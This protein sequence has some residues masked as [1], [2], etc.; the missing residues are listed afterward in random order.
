MNRSSFGTPRPHIVP[1]RT[2][3]APYV[4]LAGALANAN[5]LQPAAGQS[6][7]VRH[8]PACWPAAPFF[9]HPNRIIRD[10]HHRK[11]LDEPS[12]T[13][14]NH[15]LHHD[16]SRAESALT[17]TGTPSK[18][19]GVQNR[20]AC[21][22]HHRS[23]PAERARP[24]AGDQAKPRAYGALRPGRRCSQ[25]DGDASHA[26]SRFLVQQQLESRIGAD[27]DYLTD[28]RRRHGRC[29]RWRWTLLW[30]VMMDIRDIWRQQSEE[31]RQMKRRREKY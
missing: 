29:F 31:R 20:Y 21:F 6:R 28:P 19:H 22:L 17:V 15:H 8:N 5:L 2:T 14:R 11:L 24:E 13:D 16:P 3:T 23:P 10:L 26:S 18:S 1:T 30:Y 27:A 25:G 7:P 9:A 4:S 12:P